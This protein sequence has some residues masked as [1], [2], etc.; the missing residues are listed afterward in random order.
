MNEHCPYVLINKERLKL[1]EEYDSVL[2]RLNLAAKEELEIAIDLMRNSF[3]SIINAAKDY[4]Y[5]SDKN[6]QDQCK[7]RLEVHI[8]GYFGI[9]DK[10]KV[11][12][13]V[14]HGYDDREYTIRFRFNNNKDYELVIS[15]PDSPYWILP[16]RPMYATYEDY[17]KILSNICA[18]LRIVTNTSR[19]LRETSV[20]SDMFKDDNFNKYFVKDTI[21]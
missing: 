10:V 15:N 5:T 4:M 20:V 1:K 21:S 12:E 11:H 13:V 8:E 9:I 18:E 16:K 6:K 19:Y 2:L 17:S 14:G 7:R 3:D